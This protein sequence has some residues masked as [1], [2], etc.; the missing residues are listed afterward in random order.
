MALLLILLFELEV[1][2]VGRSITAQGHDV[3]GNFMEY[4]EYT[5][6]NFIWSMFS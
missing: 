1:R 5:K 4:G 6:V 3:D 2:R